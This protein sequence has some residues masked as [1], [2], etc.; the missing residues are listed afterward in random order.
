M[1]T[2]LAEDRSAVANAAAK[3]A[4]ASDDGNAGVSDG[5][6]VVAPFTD[7]AIAPTNMAIERPTS[8]TTAAAAP[9][10]ASARVPKRNSQKNTGTAGRASRP[11]QVVGPVGPV[12][13]AGV[14]RTRRSS[15]EQ[16][17]DARNNAERMSLKTVKTANGTPKVSYRSS[18]IIP[19]VK[20]RGDT[21]PRN[22]VVAAVKVEGGG[23]KLKVKGIK[24]VPPTDTK[25]TSTLPKRT[26]A[27]RVHK[28]YPK[29]STTKKMSQ[30]A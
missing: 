30:V 25:R 12:G 7:T 14:Q 17:I 27:G 1:T 18:G 10:A 28:P 3:V 11:S 23:G 29:P 20:V 24:P 19:V 26:S 15:V 9:T 13:V 4:L 22:S 6:L 2:M 5:D 16:T 8:S 21:L